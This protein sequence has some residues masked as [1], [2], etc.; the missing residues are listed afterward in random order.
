MIH[1]DADQTF[2][3]FT[4]CPLQTNIQLLICLS[5]DKLHRESMVKEGFVP[6]LVDMLRDY[7]KHRGLV[8]KLLYHLSVEDRTKVLFTFTDAIPIVMQVILDLVALSC[9]CCFCVLYVYLCM[10]R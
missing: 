7:A 10:F 3:L 8:F 1:V 5:F 9:S 4:I 6:R 2:A